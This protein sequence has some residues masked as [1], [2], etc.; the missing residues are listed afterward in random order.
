[1]RASQYSRSFTSQGI[2]IH[3]PRRA[4]SA[5]GRR[6]LA[7]ILREQ[8][9]EARPDVFLPL[10]QDRLEIVRFEAAEDVEHGALVVAG[11]E[12]L[13]LAVAEE[14]RNV[15]ELFR[16][17]QRRRIVRLEVVAVG[18]M[19]AVDVPERRVI[20]LLDDLE[21]LGVAGRDERAAGFALVKKVLLGHL[22]GF[23]V[24]RDEDDLDVTVFGGDE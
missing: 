16:R 22:R 4:G 18:A 12:R 10:D 19:K 24:V 14:V 9:L 7:S 17:A 5:R 20:A 13:D 3:G 21:G 15:S 8:R 11:A 2:A 23:G 1:M 6:L